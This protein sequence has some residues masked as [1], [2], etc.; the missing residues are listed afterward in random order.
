MEKFFYLPVHPPGTRPGLVSEKG[1]PVQPR[2]APNHSLRPSNP[3]C[4]VRGSR[5]DG[6]IDLR[7]HKNEPLRWSFRRR[8]C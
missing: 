3:R 1:L 6:T 5:P 7:P 4:E 2:P 8:E